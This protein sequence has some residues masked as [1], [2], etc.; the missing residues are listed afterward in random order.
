MS[1]THF[2][3]RIGIGAERFNERLNSM[4]RKN[5]ERSFGPHYGVGGLRRGAGD[6]TESGLS[7]AIQAVALIVLL[8][9]YSQHKATSN[10]SEAVQQITNLVGQINTD[11][12]S[13]GTFSGISEQEVV[14][15]G[16]VN[17]W[18]RNGHLVTPDG[19][20]VSITSD[21]TDYGDGS[22]D[23]FTWSAKYP[24][25]SCQRILMTDFGND[26]VN[27]TPSGSSS[28]A[29]SGNPAA[30]MDPSQAAAICR[31]NGQVISLTF[32]G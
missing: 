29:G 26:M 22:T 1:K 16:T 9:T 6:L 3:A 4:G 24:R 25:Q 14:D 7:L 30:P 31:Q 15:H 21:Q 11:Y 12:K 23:H 5:G 20:T 2:C 32:K 19:N 18:I 17:S 27:R 28:A 10:A 13:V 8:G